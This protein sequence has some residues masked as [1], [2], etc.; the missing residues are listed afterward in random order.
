VGENAPFRAWLASLGSDAASALA[1]AETYAALDG[2]GRDAWL[3]ALDEDAGALGRQPEL[4]EAARA[5]AYAPLLAVEEDAGRRARILSCLSATALAPR[6]T[7]MR[8]WMTADDKDRVVGVLA[9]PLVFAFVEVLACAFSPL[10]KIHDV[11]YLGLCG[12]REIFQGV[13]E[14]CAFDALFARDPDDVIDAIAHAIVSHGRTHGE[15]PTELTQCAHFFSP[16]EAS[17][18]SEAG[19]SGASR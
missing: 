17:L 11:R 4:R 15:L 10:A 19:A 3:D 13:G 16:A 5:A 14:L 12:D 18:A 7:R 9:R 1:A 8:A 2:A 6:Q